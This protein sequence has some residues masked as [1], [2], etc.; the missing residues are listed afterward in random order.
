MLQKSEAKF[1]TERHGETRR[2]MARRFADIGL[3]QGK[4][5]S[6]KVRRWEDKK[7]RRLESEKGEVGG[8]R[9][10]V[11]GGKDRSLENQKVRR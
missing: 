4:I 3:R 2:S 10:E 7:I 9:S 8:R 6:E 1:T 11:G 5:D